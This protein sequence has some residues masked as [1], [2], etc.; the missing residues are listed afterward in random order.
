MRCEGSDKAP[1]RRCEKANVEC[2]FDRKDN[3]VLKSVVTAAPHVDTENLTIRSKRGSSEETAWQTKIE[4]RV[5][6]MET[7]LNQVLLSLNGQG[8]LPA[9][10]SAVSA[11][12][13]YDDGHQT[14]DFQTHLT[15]DH[16]TLQTMPSE[17]DVSLDDSTR[18]DYFDDSKQ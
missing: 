6:S 13:T 14:L 11:N 9:P 12:H 8:A 4:N 17:Y 16:S 10:G 7:L 3:A 5:T 15:G 2:T 1:C 18:I